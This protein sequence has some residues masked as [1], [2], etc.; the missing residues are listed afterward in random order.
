MS[1]I[2]LLS[3]QT[4]REDSWKC[5][6]FVFLIVCDFKC[7]DYYIERKERWRNSC[8][9]YPFSEFLQWWNFAHPCSYLA[10]PRHRR[11]SSMHFKISHFLTCFYFNEEKKL[12]AILFF[13]KRILEEGRTSTFH[14]NAKQCQ[15]PDISTSY[16][17]V[18]A[19][20]TDV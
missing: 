1:F 9:F 12:P 6:I 8:L 10:V 14:S 13:L 5:I 4:L 11:H 20:N 17:L 18:W 19:E 15:F 3:K 7:F 16:L 2:K